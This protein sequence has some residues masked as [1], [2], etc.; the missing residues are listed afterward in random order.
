MKFR[1]LSIVTGA[2]CAAVALSQL[3][4]ADDAACQAIVAANG[5]SFSNGVSVN[6]KINKTGVDFAKATPKIFGNYSK[7]ICAYVRDEPIKGAPASVYSQRYESSAGITN[8][9]IWISKKTGL[10]LREELD[11]DLGPKG[12][13]HESM[14]FGYAK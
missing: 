10:L 5:K 13:G 12:K 4:L 3:A 11:G 6:T 14:I 8:A 9:Q 1:R 7:L 2:I